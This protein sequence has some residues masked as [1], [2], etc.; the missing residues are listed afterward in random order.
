MLAA[1][2]T[3]ASH[4]EATS[5]LAGRLAGRQG[6][7]CSLHKVK[8]NSSLSNLAYNG[9]LCDV[10]VPVVGGIKCWEKQHVVDSGLEK[11]DCLPIRARTNDWGRGDVHVRLL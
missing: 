10:C 3:S 5:R 8:C 7:R 4:A 2:G 11:G 9:D 1:A 6:A